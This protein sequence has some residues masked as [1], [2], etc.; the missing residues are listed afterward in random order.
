MTVA[1]PPQP[2]KKVD[3]AKAR[4]RMTT[5]QMRFTVRRFLAKTRGARK[6]GNRIDAAAAPG[7][8]S[9]NTTVI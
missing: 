1:W 9:V 5:N 2:E 8:V 4:P 3:A 7:I 6:N